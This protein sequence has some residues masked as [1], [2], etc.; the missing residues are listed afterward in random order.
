MGAAPTILPPFMSQAA[1]PEWVR[2][3]TTEC[4]LPSLA[5]VTVAVTGNIGGRTG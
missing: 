5:N 4:F 1:M 2:N 3:T